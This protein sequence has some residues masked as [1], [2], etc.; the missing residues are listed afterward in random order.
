MYSLIVA[1]SRFGKKASAK[2]INVNAI[3]YKKII[4]KML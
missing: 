4:V 1:V 3:W 2:C